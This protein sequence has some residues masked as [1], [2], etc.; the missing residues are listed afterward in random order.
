[1]DEKSCDTRCPIST[2]LGLLVLRVAAGASLAINHGWVKFH[3]P[4]FKSKFFG[5]V[6]GMGLPASNALAWAAIAAELVGGV[7]LALGFLT[8]VSAF[9]ILCVMGVAIWKVHLPSHQ[10][11]AGMEMAVLY[12]AIAVAFLL[13]GAGRISVDGM[14][15]CRGKKSET[16]SEADEPMEKF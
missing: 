12:G 11:F 5:M 14:L 10:G 16:T 6:G 13:S 4:D 7:L 8:R 2:S 15:F 1:M 3:D 9:M